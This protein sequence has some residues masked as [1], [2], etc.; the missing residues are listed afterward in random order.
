MSYSEH[1]QDAAAIVAGCAVVTISDSRTEANDASGATI[2]RLVTEAGHKVVHYQIVR[3]DPGELEAMLA[4]LLGRADID[5]I[6]SS[7][8]TGL[9]RRD[10]TVAVLRRRLDVS[11]DGFG[12]LFRSLSYQEIGSGAMMSRALGGVA[13]GKLLF[14]MPGS[15]SAVELAMSKLILPELRHMIGQI[16]K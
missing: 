8:G 14:A 9:S 16:R 5:A 6:F 13:R 15:T 11:L 3:N 2:K 7:G 1:Q 4:R 10:Q 12:E